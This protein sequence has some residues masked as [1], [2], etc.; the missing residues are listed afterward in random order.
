MLIAISSSLTVLN[1]SR[2][3]N[4]LAVPSASETLPG[5]F[6]LLTPNSASYIR[7]DPK[8]SPPPGRLP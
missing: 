4:E 1:P 3:R 6:F 7:A 8:P 2:L 5:A